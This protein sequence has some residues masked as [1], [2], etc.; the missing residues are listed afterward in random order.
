MAT[1]RQKSVRRELFEREKEKQKPVK[2]NIARSRSVIEDYILRLANML[3]KQGKE[4]HPMVIEY[5]SEPRFFNALPDIIKHNP[6]EMLRLIETNSKFYNCINDPALYGKEI[7]IKDSKT[8]S[9]HTREEEFGRVI[10]MDYLRLRKIDPTRILFFRITQP[11][12]KPKPEYYWTCDLYETLKGLRMEISPE[13]RKTAVVLIANL[14]TLNNTGGLIRD[15]NDDSGIS[16]RL[17]SNK[18]F[19]QKYAIAKFLAMQP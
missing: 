10:N 9:G 16:I 6:I 8:D 7:Q 2:T 5:F 1:F 17:I 15:K 3:L 13:K 12:N 19:N 4:V 14:E 18:P 11:S